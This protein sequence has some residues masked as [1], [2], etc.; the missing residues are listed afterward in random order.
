MHRYFIKTPWIAKKIFASYV[1]NLPAGENAVYL[2]FD[3]GPH[4][5]ITSW[6]LEQLKQYNAKA[7]FFCIGN[8]VEKY[9]DIY[10]KILDEDHATGNHTHHHLN[11][12]KTK[13]RK[14]LDDISKA[15]QLI[16]SNLFR[17]P[18]GRIKSNQAKKIAIALQTDKEQII[19]WDVLSADFDSSFSPEQCLRHVLENV[20]AGSIVVFHDSEKAFNNLK[21]VLPATL[22]YLKEEGF[23]FKKIEI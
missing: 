18:Y 15:A 22:R 8:N 4:P 7:T 17:P 23:D 20:S 2:T 11:G 12:W 10:Q 21:H 5:I 14:Y 16:K 13:D 19:M 3:D 1:W 6:V 9:P